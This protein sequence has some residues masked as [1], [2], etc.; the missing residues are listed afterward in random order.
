MCHVGVIEHDAGRDAE[1]D[2]QDGNYVGMYAHLFKKSGPDVTDGA[3]GVNVQ[4]FFRIHGF[5]GSRESAV[6]FFC[7]HL[8][9]S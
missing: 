5:E 1:D 2:G 4:Q 8:I 6:T 7:I 9:V 3:V